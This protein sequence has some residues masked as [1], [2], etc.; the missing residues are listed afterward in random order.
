MSGHKPHG[1]WF[2][3]H[4]EVELGKPWRNPLGGCF[5][6][7]SSGISRENWKMGTNTNQ[8]QIFCMI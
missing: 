4:A 5:P 3:K 6:T 2:V 7:M 8:P 1:T